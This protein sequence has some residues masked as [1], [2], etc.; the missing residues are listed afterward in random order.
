MQ[1]KALHRL[2]VAL[3]KSEVSILCLY[4]ELVIFIRRTVEPI[5]YTSIIHPFSQLLSSVLVAILLALYH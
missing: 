5:H 3:D 2:Y 1:R 4:L